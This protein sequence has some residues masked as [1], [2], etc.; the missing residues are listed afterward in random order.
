MFDRI[1]DIHYWI[2]SSTAYIIGETILWWLLLIRIW[3]VLVVFKKAT[4][5]KPCLFWPVHEVRFNQS[6]F[7]KMNLK[8]RI[9][10]MS[11]EAANSTK[12]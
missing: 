6:Q 8:F 4:N 11:D 2:N 10:Q 12:T 7:A 9:T 1:M 5:T 3:S